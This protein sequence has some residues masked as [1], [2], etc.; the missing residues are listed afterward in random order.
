MSTTKTKTEPKPES[1]TQ[2]KPDDKEIRLE[3]LDKIRDSESLVKDA[4]VNLGRAKS[5]AVFC[6]EAVREATEKLRRLVRNGTAPLPLFEQPKEMS[7]DPRLAMTISKLD[8][9]K[10]IFNVF[11][12]QKIKTVGNLMEWIKDYKLTE[13]KGIG[14]P[15]AKEIEAALRKFLKENKHRGE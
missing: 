2:E 13:M 3:L 6:R 1:K 12:K 4:E 5:H 10:A 7:D 9:S 8:V 14:E 11:D 15:K